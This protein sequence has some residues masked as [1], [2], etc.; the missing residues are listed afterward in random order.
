MIQRWKEVYNML[1]DL[2]I[3]PNSEC[4]VLIY[5]IRRWSTYISIYHYELFLTNERW[6]MVMNTMNV[7][8]IKNNNDTK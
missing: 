1:L 5:M 3:L 8:G 6:N 2:V 7:V 4:Q